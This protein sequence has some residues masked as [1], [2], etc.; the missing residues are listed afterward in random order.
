[1]SVGHLPITYLVLEL[2]VAVFAVLGNLVIMIVFG[3]D[4][5][6]R[7]L[8]NFYILSLATAD[9]LVGLVGVPSAILTKLGLPEGN[10]GGCM[11]MLSLLVVLCTISILNL[12]AVS[13]DRYWAVLHPFSYQKM[14]TGRAVATII[15]GCWFLG[16]T[17]GFLPLFGWNSGP[18]TSGRCFF[19]QVMNYN[20]L[21]FLYFATIIYPTLLM[22][23]CYG[24]IY[25]VVLKQASKVSY[26]KVYSFIH[27]NHDQTAKIRILSH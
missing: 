13:V 4:K 27:I 12:L 16:T 18:E 25:R 2:T 8:T 14:M 5:S 26:Q 1:M 21:V 10:F 9:F 3:L 6:I 15:L 11:T 23:F 7:K 17:I 24:K 19:A 22:A 20:F